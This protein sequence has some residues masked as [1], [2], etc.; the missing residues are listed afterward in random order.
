[1]EKEGTPTVK[2]SLAADTDTVGRSLSMVESEWMANE[3][4]PAPT[5]LY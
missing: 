3:G 4:L 1:M 2:M 5:L